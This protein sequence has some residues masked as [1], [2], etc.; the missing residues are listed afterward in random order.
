MQRNNQFV[1][2]LEAGASPQVILKFLMQKSLEGHPKIFL[3]IKDDPD[4]VFVHQFLDFLA[5][6]IKT[7]VCITEALELLRLIN[8]CGSTIAHAIAEC[9]TADCAQYYLN[10][11]SEV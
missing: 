3:M 10:F 7:N 11:L 9:C 1:Q 6:C 4:S 2:L 5:E 8:D